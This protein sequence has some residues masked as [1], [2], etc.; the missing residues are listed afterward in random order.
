MAKPKEDRSL[1]PSSI[2]EPVTKLYSVARAAGRLGISKRTLYRYIKKNEGS[3]RAQTVEQNGRIKL[4]EEGIGIAREMIS[5]GT[6]SE[7]I[8]FEESGLAP[9][10]IDSSVPPGPDP[11][12]AVLPAR[13]GPDELVE[14]LREQIKDLKEERMRL[15]GEAEEL[16]TA[17]KTAREE[18]DRLLFEVAEWRGLYGRI[19]DQ[20]ALV[21]HQPREGWVSK[22][23]QKLSYTFRAATKDSQK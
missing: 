5:R 18:R 7:N 15:I 19:E 13:T 22:A 11:L 1:L 8:S 12:L 2:V 3:L 6:S 21:V 10:P 9:P 16:K 17:T 20:R 14:V 4:T 23:W